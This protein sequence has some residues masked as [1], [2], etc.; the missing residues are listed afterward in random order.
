AVHAGDLAA[1]RSRL[2]AGVDPNTANRHGTTAL[3]MAADAGQAEVARLLV[4]RGAD[5]NARDRFFH[6]SPL[7]LALGRGHIDLGLWLLPRTREVDG[8]LA[9]AVESKD[10]RLLGAV[11]AT[12]RVEPLE[13]EAA[14]R[15]AAEAKA[16]ESLRRALEEAR[17][18]RPARAAFP[19]APERLARL[20]GRYRVG[21]S[22]E[23]TVA[24]QGDGLVLRIPGRPDIVARPIS[25]DRFE[26]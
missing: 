10:E 22:G 8:A 16:P 21:Q 20:A 7:E 2:D 24:V 4:E 12:G 13:L 6:A 15:A 9:Q 3:A 17:A 18:K 1:V 11:L 26:S 5:V 23:A 14:R 19:A 25:E